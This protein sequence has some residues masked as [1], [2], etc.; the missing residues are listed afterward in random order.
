MLRALRSSRSASS[1]AV[2]GLAGPLSM[3]ARIRCRPGQARHTFPCMCTSDK[4]LCVVGTV[5]QRH[6]SGERSTYLALYLLRLVH[7]RYD[8]DSQHNRRGK[9]QLR[10]LAGC[11]HVASLFSRLNT[12]CRPLSTVCCPFC[13]R[14][15][16]LTNSMFNQ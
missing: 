13:I 10:S 9:R 3:C 14:T 4:G 6:V 7:K 2:G 12:T 5:G 8:A 1:S 16:P 15:T 11:A